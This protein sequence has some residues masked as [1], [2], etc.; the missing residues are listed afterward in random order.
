MAGMVEGD[1]MAA[2]LHHIRWLGG[3][4]GAGKSTIARRLAER[5]GLRLYQCDAMEPDHV[6][7]AKREEHP[8][9]FR[10]LEMSMDE[11][12]VL[13]SPAEMLA[14]LPAAQGEGFQLIL[15]DLLALP[16]DRPILAEGY[17]L[18]PR[19][20]RPL[21]GAPQRAMWLIPTP[22]IRRA[23][24]EMRGTLWDMPRQTSDPERALVN[25]LARDALFSDLI[26][27]EAAALDLRCVIVDGSRDLEQMT[28]EVERL[29]DLANDEHSDGTRR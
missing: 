29:L 8:L 4:T 5:H 3:G 6:A 7:R 25:R 23:G 15:D 20:V 13:R 1:T 10:F 12:W 18:L 19:L 24:L 21:L 17:K 27:R 28:E 22:G 9:L 11:R 2:R 26:A 14:T 16:T